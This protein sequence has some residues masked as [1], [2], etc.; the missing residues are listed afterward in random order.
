MRASGMRGVIIYC[1]DY[2]CSHWIRISA[3]D[4]SD[5][6]RLSDLEN[7]FACTA[8]GTRGADVRQ[9]FDWDKN[10]IRSENVVIVCLL[11]V[12][13]A[14]GKQYGYRMD[15]CHMESSHWLHED[16]RRLRSLLR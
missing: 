14:N 3:D 16:Q 5:D 13:V 7:R 15:G 11:R 1:V 6:V 4:W 8:C 2:K 10:T 9:D 12:G